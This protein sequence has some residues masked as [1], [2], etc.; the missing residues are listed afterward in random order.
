MRGVCERVR[1]RFASAIAFSRSRPRAAQQG[2]SDQ[3]QWYG[4]SILSR[5]PVHREGKVLTARRRRRGSIR[6]FGQSGWAGGRGSPF[7]RLRKP[8]G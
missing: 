4:V 3:S 2:V 6:D 1:L 5:Q 8:V 7:R